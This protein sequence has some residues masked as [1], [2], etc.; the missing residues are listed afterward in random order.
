MKELIVVKKKYTRMFTLFVP[1]I[2]LYPQYILTL[3]SPFMPLYCIVLLTAMV[4]FTYWIH[5]N[6]APDFSL[7]RS[8][9]RSIGMEWIYPLPRP[10][11]DRRTIFACHPH[12]I[13]P[14]SALSFVRQG[15]PVVVARNMLATI[16][17]P[18]GL[19]FMGL[20]DNSRETVVRTIQDYRSLA[21]YPGGADE[22]CQADRDATYRFVRIRDGII[23]LAIEHGCAIVPTWVPGE[24]DT[25]TPVLCRYN[26][27]KSWLWETL[28][29]PFAPGIGRYG[30][31]GMP[32]R[33][34]VPIYYG[35][36]IECRPDIDT[37]EGIREQ[38]TRELVRLAR[39]SGHR[40]RTVVR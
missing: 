14:S 3:V 13:V 30:I 39:E 15:I 38:Y 27:W 23:R 31:P 7:V 36:P 12:G 33:G 4:V 40:I 28:R 2:A 24:C 16:L 17:A 25:V 6:G 34:A 11:T 19:K 20:V 26:R 18:F 9:E 10:R 22:M 21:I 1:I 29:I 8:V 32:V 35:N 5:D 37:V